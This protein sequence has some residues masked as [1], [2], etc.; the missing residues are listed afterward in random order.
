M[1]ELKVNGKTMSVAAEAETPLLWAIREHLELTGS[2]P[3]YYLGSAG[4]SLMTAAGQLLTILFLGDALIGSPLVLLQ[5]GL[6]GLGAI[7]VLLLARSLIRR[8]KAAATDRS[9]QILLLSMPLYPLAIA[10][11]D[12]VHGTRT[13]FITKT[14][15]LLFPLI[16]LL[17]MRAWSVGLSSRL[18]TTGLAL[19]ALLLATA[20]GVTV[21]MNFAIFQ[22]DHRSVARTLAASDRPE[23]LVLFNSMIRGHGIPLLLLLCPLP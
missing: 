19:G 17:V 18:R 22:D 5:W 8:D 1:V 13:A 23:H 12:L 20:S 16:L 11:A 9:V 6:L 15:L 14:S 10:A 4:P 3:S 21:Y 7:T 2:V